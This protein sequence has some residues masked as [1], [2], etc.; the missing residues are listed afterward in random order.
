MA[1]GRIDNVSLARP[2]IKIVYSAK[3]VFPP[4]SVVSRSS[5]LIDAHHGAYVVELSE[6]VADDLDVVYVVHAEAYVA[7]EDA[8]MGLD[9]DTL[10]IHVELL[11]DDVR[12]LVGDTYTIDTLDVD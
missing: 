1:Q 3:L 9:E 10:H 6:V 12:D 4:Y 7:V 11:G 2:K 8:V 5:F